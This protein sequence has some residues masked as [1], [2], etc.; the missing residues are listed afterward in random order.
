MLAYIVY[1]TEEEL[2]LLYEWCKKYDVR[3]GR[4]R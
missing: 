3:W 2:E 4:W 1:Y